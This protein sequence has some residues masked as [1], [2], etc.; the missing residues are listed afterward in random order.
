MIEYLITDFTFQHLL[1][2]AIGCLLGTAVGLLPGLGPATAVSLLLPVAI[3]LGPISGIAFLSGIYYGSQY[4]GSTTAILFNIP[5]ESSSIMTVKDGHRLAQTGQAGLAIFSAGVSSFIGGIVATILLILFAPAI[6]DVAFA[7]GPPEYTLMILLAFIVISA[8]TSS[9]TIVSGFML[10]LLG[11]LVGMIGVDITSGVSRFSLDIPDLYDGVNFIAL[12]VAFFAVSEISYNFSNDKV[13]VVIKEKF[14]FDN[15]RQNLLKIIP[16]ALRGT[17]V[18]S[19]LGL[20][21]G[22]GITISSYAAYSVESKYSNDLGTGSVAGVS[23]PEAANNASAHA[24][25]IPLLSMGLPENAVM[26]IML[27]ALMM[28]GIIPGPAL[29]S[30]NSTVFWGIAASML[31][32]N[33]LLLVL[34]VPL[35]RVWTS[36]LLIPRTILLPLIFSISLISVYSVRNNAFD[37]LILAI[38]SVIGYLFASL[39]LEIVSFIIGFILGP[40]LETMLKRSLTISGGDWSIF[41]HNWITILMLSAI[42]L[43]IAYSYIK[44]MLNKLIDK[45]QETS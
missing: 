4:G 45:Q 30:E 5:G 28:M 2:T 23:A 41:Y 1:Y 15:I 19:I 27:G 9:G 25:Y 44:L 13:A 37:V 43:V 20:L 31:I 32:G 10:S 42:I 21:P 11:S 35:I 22:G 16:P 7:F 12:T 8:V 3:T 39:R 36:L 29:I 6:A 40:K 14:K 18:G 34:N 24:G 17:A 26:A 33:V 38:L